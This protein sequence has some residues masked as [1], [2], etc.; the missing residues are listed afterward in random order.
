M[1]L[2]LIRESERVWLLLLACILAAV[3]GSMAMAHGTEKH[4]EETKAAAAEMPVIPATG[5]EAMDH[6]AMAQQDMVEH[7]EVLVDEIAEPAAKGSF[8]ANIHPATV[9]FPIALFIVAGMVEA[10]NMRRR[11][12]R[13]SAA[14]DVMVVAGALG[15][16]IAATFGWVH[17]GL[18]LGG[19]AAM[20]WHRWIGTG[21]A[22]VGALAAWLA[23]RD[24]GRTGLRIALL[25]LVAG[26]A[27]Q[28]YL[29]GEI[30]HG[31]G[32]LGF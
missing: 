7:G 29:G 20:N 28:G 16:V 4:G 27:V 3:A 30:S 11:R 8:W 5:A 26:A 32:H 15:A 17:T 10:L 25:L 9:H 19:D 22:L 18:W 12:E 14:V 13:L 21:L 1:S 6:S 23:I 31:V 24:G 2:R